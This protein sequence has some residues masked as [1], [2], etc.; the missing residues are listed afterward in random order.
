MA[1]W[2]D[3]DTELINSEIVSSVQTG[4]LEASCLEN[5]RSQ[6]LS[7]AECQN[8]V[9]DILSPLKLLGKTPADVLPLTLAG[10]VSPNSCRGCVRWQDSLQDCS[11]GR[12]PCECFTALDLRRNL[13]LGDTCLGRGRK[14]CY[15]GGILHFGFCKT[16]KNKESGRKNQFCVQLRQGSWDGQGGKGSYITRNNS[17]VCQQSPP[18]RSELCLVWI[19]FFLIFIQRATQ[20]EI[21]DKIPLST[22][23]AVAA[24]G[25]F[26]TA[27]Y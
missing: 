20:S 18:V 27:Q 23:K 7:A 11:S 4:R 16:K 24:G 17:H 6:Y 15:R 9:A 26:I 22:G 21:I 10:S 2:T 19:S 5:L 3:Y 1:G 12:H 8:S 25:T 14:E 13:S